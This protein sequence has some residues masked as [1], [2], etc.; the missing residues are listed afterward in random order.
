VSSKATYATQ[1]GLR[2]ILRTRRKILNRG[3]A[4]IN[5]TCTNVAFVKCCVA[6]VR[7]ETGLDGVRVDGVFD[8]A[9]PLPGTQLI[10]VTE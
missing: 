1:G 9:K 8:V 2:K 7:V 10:D 5:R 6:C 4:R 3:L